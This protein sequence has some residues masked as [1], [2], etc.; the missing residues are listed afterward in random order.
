MQRPAF[1]PG[2]TQQFTAPVRRVINKDGSFNV[3]RRGTSWHDVHPYLQLVNLSW[4]AFLATLFAGYIV[5]NTF[6]ATLYFLFAPGQL[7]AAE[8]NTAI[9][10]FFNV[11][12]FSAQTLSTVGYGVIAPKGLAANIIAAFEAMFGVL[13]FAV[14]TGLLF[15]RVSRPSAKLGYSENMLVAPYQDGTSLQ[16]RVVNRRRNDLMELEARVMLMTV[17]PGNGRAVRKYTLLK[18]EREK[19]LFLPLSWTIVH[20]IDDESPLRGLTAEDLARLQLEV[21]ILIK[22][23]DDTFS[24]TVLSR[25]SY[26][27]EE[28]L[29]NRRFAP[30]FDVSQDGDLIL[31]LQK[32]GQVAETS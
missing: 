15:G 16:F 11:F 21:L 27:H 7:S 9:G 18:L 10:R 8:S 24:Q 14:A 32:V 2:L 17:E 26:R 5:V 4:P 23:Y 1:D 6:F 30:A 29:W 25:H 19:V 28:I 13:G 31:E 22:G 12:F 20:P 3:L